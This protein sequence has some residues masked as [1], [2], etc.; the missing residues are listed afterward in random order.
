MRMLLAMS[1]MLCLVLCAASCV[2]TAETP[3]DSAAPASAAGTAADVPADEAAETPDDQAAAEDEKPATDPAAEPDADLPFETKTE[4]ISY[5][6][7]VDIGSNMKRQGVEIDPEIL[8][9]G[10][11]DALFDREV[12]IDED[13][14]HEILMAFSNEIRQEQ[15]RRLKEMAE[16]NQKAADAF[17]AENAKK[18][19]VVTLPSGLQYKVIAEGDGPT[20]KRTDTVSTHYRGTLLDGTEFDSS[21]NR[22]QPAK[23]PV[24]GVIRGW[25]EALQ[26]MKVGS[27]WHL[28]VPPALAYGER[29]GRNIEPNSAL[30]FEI[31]LLGIEEPKP[32]RTPRARTRPATTRPAAPDAPK[33]DAEP[34]ATPDA[35]PKPDEEAK[36]V[37]GQE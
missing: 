35:Q 17:L 14:R 18:E 5:C 10:L 15:Q 16:A 8:A 6:I 21:H 31:E 7:G 37:E 32:A 19:G 36:P 23:F 28:F 24:G 29:G 27:K 12:L 3:A 2:E 9:K 26:L 1:A 25:T 11:S 30:I 33:P 4:R 22:G 13:K 20:P 34:D